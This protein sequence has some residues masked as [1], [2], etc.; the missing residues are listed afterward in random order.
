MGLR[1]CGAASALS[2]PVSWAPAIGRNCPT[3]GSW[4]E[5]SIA[6]CISA[7]RADSNGVRCYRFDRGSRC[8]IFGNSESGLTNAHWMMWV[9]EP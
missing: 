1:A 3:V 9:K 6:E 2:K 5:A 8:R 7:I 4:A